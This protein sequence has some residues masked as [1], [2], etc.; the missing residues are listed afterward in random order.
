ME[1]GTGKKELGEQNLDTDEGKSVDAIKWSNGIG[2]SLSDS[3]PFNSVTC[4]TEQ[5]HGHAVL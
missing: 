1:W 2:L 3:H 5:G 4:I